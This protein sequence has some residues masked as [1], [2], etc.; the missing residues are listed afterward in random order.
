MYNVK[1]IRQIIHETWDTFREMHEVNTQTWNVPLGN[2]GLSSVKLYLINKKYS[3][4]S[5]SAKV[6]KTH[7]LNWN[8]ILWHR[9][10]MGCVA[11]HYLVNSFLYKIT[12]RKVGDLPQCF[13]KLYF[14]V[15]S[16]ES[17]H[18]HSTRILKKKVDR[19]RGLS[20]KSLNTSLFSELL[21]H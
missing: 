12:T 16:A 1:S 5:Q 7:S 6:T 11:F 9:Y 21:E 3:L 17:S 13:F 8:V 10:T 20:R 4:F 19:Q 14:V 18:W 2:Q 15:T